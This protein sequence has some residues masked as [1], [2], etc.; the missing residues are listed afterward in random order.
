MSQV[1]VYTTPTCPYCRYVKQ[2]LEG[3]GV[4]YNE[5]NVAADQKAAIEMVSRSGQQGVPVTVI[6]EEVIVGFNQ[7]ALN[8]AVIKLKAQSGG[9]TNG[10]SSSLKL[11]AKVADAATVL[12]KQDKASQVGV[13][14][15]SVTP[16]SLAE[17]AGLHEGDIIVALG[18]HTIRNVADLQKALS[19][20]GGLPFAELGGTAGLAF[21]RNG[22]YLQ[23]KLP[24]K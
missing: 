8:Q 6:G 12:A 16:G 19:V 5:K 23:S 10:S 2:F 3:K 9:A 21:V 1:T 17:K 22:Q 4:P 15:G 18:S 14:L 24:L 20:M 13:L 11:G 7:P